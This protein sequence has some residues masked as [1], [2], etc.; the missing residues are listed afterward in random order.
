MAR[1]EKEH[2]YRVIYREK[3]TSF[4]EL[5]EVVVYLKGKYFYQVM[6]SGEDITD[7]ISWLL[8]M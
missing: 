8:K 6:D 1:K 2:I 4:K 7:T 3:V 5:G